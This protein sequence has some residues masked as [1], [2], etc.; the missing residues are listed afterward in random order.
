MKIKNVFSMAK[1]KEISH[2]GDGYLHKVRS[3]DKDFFRSPID[4]I[5]YVIMSPG[6]TIGYHSH[7]LDE[8]IYF[9][10]KGEGQ[11]IIEDKKTRIKAGDII[12]NPVNGSHALINDTPENIE[13]FIFQVNAHN[14]SKFIK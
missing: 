9:I 6:T 10:L 13:I 14:T 8:E 3:H 4:F 1:I 5:D 2:N 12:V 11:M 7:D